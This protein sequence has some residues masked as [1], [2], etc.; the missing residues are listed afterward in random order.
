MTR[1]YSDLQVVQGAM[2]SVVDTGIYMVL[3]ALGA[4]IALLILS[5]LLAGLVFLVVPLFAAGY[6]AL[7]SRLRKA[8]YARQQ[9]SG[10]LSSVLQENLTAH[11]V[12]KAFG[13]EGRW[14][15][16]FHNRLQSFFRSTMRLVLLGSLFETST[17]L[18]MTLGQLLVLGVG[19]Y[20]AMQ[21]SLT[22]GSLLAFFGFLPSIFTPVGALAN[23]GQ[24]VQTASGSLERVN[25]L[26][27]EP[28]TIAEKDGA[29]T[30]PPLSQE[31][32]LEHVNFSYA[33]DRPI[34]KDLSL[35]IPAGAHV[36]I[37]GPSGSGKSTVVNL[38]LRYWDP[39]AGRVCS[40]GTT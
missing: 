13:L 31:I 9:L 22:V 5:P 6:F 33:N 38:L 26:L 11:A 21:G 15:E 20:L 8:S 34:L 29:M 39:E 12:V 35:T 7:R 3:S 2:M 32:K 18:A 1:V 10:E 40:T 23:L 25:E 37:V 17:D 14:K 16:T 4:S 19:G 36:A 24:T 28:V 27:D 30:L